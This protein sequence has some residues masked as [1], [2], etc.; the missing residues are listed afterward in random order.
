MNQAALAQKQLLLQQQMMIM[1]QAQ[2]LQMMQQNIAQ[3]GQAQFGVNAGNGKNITFN[4]P[5]ETSNLMGPATQIP[6]EKDPFSEI[7]EMIMKNN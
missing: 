5:A 1:Q 4:K 3:Q 7:G 6:K 2:Q